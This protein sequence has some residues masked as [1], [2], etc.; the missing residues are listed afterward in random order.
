MTGSTAV[1]YLMRGSGVS[2][3]LLLTGV[4][5]LGILT[6]RKRSLPTLPRF[7]TMELHRSISLLAVVFLAVHVLTAVSD[8]YA[9][10]RLVDVIAPFD[11]FMLGLGTL[12]LDLFAAVIVSSLL[13]RRISRAPSS[14]RSAWA[15][16][17]ARSG[18]ARSRSAASP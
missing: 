7:A 5:V 3:L 15:R 4:V 9:Q 12:A 1:W 11:G 10:V 14:T 17:R 6:S 18:C 8:P 16:M 2:S 13:I